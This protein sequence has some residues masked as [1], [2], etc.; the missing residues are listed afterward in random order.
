MITDKDKKTICDLSAKYRAKRV[1]LFGSSLD[2]VRESHD[3]D[4]AVEGI[5]PE[6]FFK[7]YGDLLLNLSK[8][9]DIIDL[10]TTSKF[11]QLV[12]QGGI[13]LY[14]KA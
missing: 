12:E 1:L 8:P 7:Y 3:I 4:I 13:L 14:G 2:P 9:V 11:V 6:S 5:A 10:S